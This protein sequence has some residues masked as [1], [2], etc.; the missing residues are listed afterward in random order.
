[1]KDSFIDLYEVLQVSPNADAETIQRV[2]RHL[3]QRYHPD[4]K[5][6]GDEEAFKL[7]LAA[8]RILGDPERRAAYDSE[9]SRVRQLRWR[10]FD[11]PKATQGVEAERRKRQGI[12]ALLYTKRLHQPDEPGMKIKELEELLGCPR[13]HLEFALW[14]LRENQ[15]IVRADSGYYVITAKGVDAAEASRQT[16]PEDARLLP[17]PQEAGAR[18]ERNAWMAADRIVPTV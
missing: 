3:A 18:G 7:L 10:I 11:Q 4:N 8:H 17:A 1:M 12:L 2:Y 13:E 16:R 6:T 9:H 14:Y 5:E 15:W